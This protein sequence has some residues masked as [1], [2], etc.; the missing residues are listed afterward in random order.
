M[1]ITRQTEY[2]IRTVMELAKLEEGLL[3]PAKV[4]AA[5]QGF[6]EGFLKKTIQLL[7]HAGLITTQRGT[8]GGVRLAVP[9]AA[10]TIADIM[11]AVEGT[12]AINPCISETYI[13]PNKPE[14]QM[15]AVF[16]R[17]QSAM[18][19]ELSKESIADLVE[20][21]YIYSIPDKQ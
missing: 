2:A 1:Q 6:P 15:R 21:N 17:T 18:L 8:Q 11:I 4:I 5:Y 14:C 7:A 16:Q 19:K 13:C 10:I 20:K 9:A 12:L 3:M